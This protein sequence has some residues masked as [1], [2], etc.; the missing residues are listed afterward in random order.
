MVAAEAED[1]MDDT[2]SPKE[3]QTSDPRDDVMAV[4]RAERSIFVA[5]A[6]YRDPDLCNTVR[7]LFDKAEDPDA[8]RIGI[9][10]QI[11]PE[12]DADCLPQSP[13]PEQTEVL[14]F[15]AKDSRGACW[16][17]SQM[18]TL[19]RDES[20]YFQIDSHMRFVEGWDRVL[21]EMLASAPSQKPV[22][23]TYP[24]K[25]DPP[26]Q[27]GE[28]RYITIYSK[29][30]TLDGVLMQ[31]S[32]GMSIK[33]APETLQDNS[34]IGAGLVFARGDL[35]NEIPYDPHLYFQGEEITL[36]ARMYTSGWDIYTP[37]RVVAYHDYTKKPD[38]PRHWEDNENW[39]SLRQ[40]AVRRL[41][42]IFEMD[43]R[44]PPEDD[45]CWTDLDLY[46]LGTERS[47]ADFEAFS[48][49]DFRARVINGKPGNLPER[50]ADSDDEISR[51]KRVFTNIYTNN[52]W[53][54]AETRSG[55]GSTMGAT[56]VIRKSLA[57]LFHDLDISILADAGCGDANWIGD[58]VDPL[59]LYLGFDIVEEAA[60]EAR[61]KLVGKANCVVETADVVLRT[62]PGCDAILCRDV[63]THLP[64]D[65]AFMALQKFKASGSRFLIATTHAIGRNRWV[66]T[67]GWYTCDLMAPPF[68]LPDPMIHLSESLSGSNKEL[69][70]WRLDTLSMLD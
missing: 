37:N 50:P 16:A 2:E 60:E 53:K 63:L 48:K 24:V 17:R 68:S 56:Q 35:V 30:F 62:L 41:R 4:D 32:I 10:L 69:G 31:K 46:T 59:R 1:L 51:R 27:L 49:V 19:F 13:R 11:V 14:E 64:S 45:P 47:L 70:V 39:V 57:Q 29:G 23:S 65:A 21:L 25:F 28:D 5:I 66:S 7:D 3:A 26:D 22:L 61:A 12:E 20:Y 38:R 9:C 34:H 44:K 36:A 52:D 58:I 6:S 55:N 18:Q 43:A 33:D 15:H 67:G 54:N 40:T 8:L 42:Q